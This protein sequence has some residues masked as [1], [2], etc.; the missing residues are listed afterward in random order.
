[1]TNRTVTYMGIAQSFAG[2][3]Q[4]NQTY[5]ISAWVRLVV[6][7]NQSVYLTFQKTDG[8]GTT[9]AQAATGTATASGWTQ[10]SGQ[11]TLTY[12][13]ALS[14]LTLYAE[15]PNSATGA[16]YIDDLSVQLANIPP[17]NGQCTVD[18]NTTCQRIDGFGGGVQF[19]SPATLD[20]VPTSTMDTLFGIGTNQLALTLLRIGIDPNNNWNNQLLDAQKAVAR[21]AGVL[22]TP[23]S[24]P[25]AM[26]DN[27][28]TIGGSLFPR[29]TRTMHITSTVSPHS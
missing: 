28:S 29:N 14:A 6:G 12:S 16:Y 22:A 20:P 7:A 19:L 15:L 3:L 17:T 21:G 11:Y 24:P 5:N 10:I 4:T 27:G 18:W 1:M 25:A 23:W 9:Y 2:V 13:G 26:K 8:G